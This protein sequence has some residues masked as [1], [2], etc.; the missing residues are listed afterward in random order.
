M[1][2]TK[3]WKRRAG[4]FA[5]VVVMAGCSGGGTASEPLVQE[6]PPGWRYPQA[7]SPLSAAHGMVV[8]TDS[9]ASAAGLSMLQA[10]GNAVDAAVATG[11][12]LAVVNPEAGNIGGGGFLVARM[13][14]DT[15]VAL[16]YREKAPLAATADMYLDADGRVTDAGVLG[17]LASGVPG[18]V[19]GMEAAWSRFGTL[20]WADLL[21]PAIRLARDGFVIAPRHLSS[22]GA[23]AELL[24]RFPSTA[25]VFLPG[26][27]PPQIGSVF[28]Q[29]DLARALQSIADEGAAA[30][31]AGWIADS[32]V[33][34]MD[35]GG[36]LITHEDLASYDAV[37][38]DPV[39]LD[40]RGH[41]V[42]TMPPPSSGGVTMGQILNIVESFDL[43]SMGWLS[44]DHVHVAVEG[45]RRAYADRN[46]FLGDPDF[47]EIPM[48]RL[49]SQAYADSLAGTID[50]R[51]ASDSRAFNRV[52]EES[53]QTTHYSIV[54]REG[55][56]VA[57]TTTINSW[58]GS[59][60][61]VR[62]AG[63]LLNNEMDDFT[64]KPGVPNQF[65][66]VQGEANA[67]APGKRMLSAMTPT[68]VVGPEGRTELVTGTPGGATI[69][70]TIFQ[71][72]TNHVDF[73][74]PVRA[75]VDAPRF[76]HQ[77]LP[78][79]LRYE[80][81]G[82]PPAIV[83]ELQRRGHVLEERTGISGDVQSIHVLEDGTLLGAADRRRGGQA[84]G[85]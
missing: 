83:Q 15:R 48:G 28:R 42:I 55:N 12:T 35:R 19:A 51:L 82:L 33:A 74:L 52:P 50:M 24:L 58:F 60:V 45:M 37:W 2:H 70:T 65:G 66:L 46:Y 39:V 9:L 1:N 7:D 76:H 64:S 29:P 6:F 62:G 69:I 38:R 41:E 31:Y 5:F 71:A 67:I 80:P 20:P 44:A 63:Y 18:S 21:E 22:V 23:R 34:E 27:E 53:T 77:H 73:G 68:I 40:Y 85:Y 10:G 14:D 72:V 36:G 56:A 4:T 78:D 81:S 25:A 75:S 84:L 43:A 32:T 8:S 3:R 49:L 59:K 57:V 79:L 61:V 16:D 17:H 54:D 11:F 30:F 26:G 13:A 47:V